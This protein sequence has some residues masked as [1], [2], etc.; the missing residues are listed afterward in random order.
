M[1]LFKIFAIV[2]LACLVGFT[3]FAVTPGG[4]KSSSSQAE[5]QH[6]SPFAFTYVFN[7]HYIWIPVTPMSFVATTT[8]ADS[9]V[10][11]LSP[12]G[13]AGVISENTSSDILSLA[14]DANAEDFSVMIPCPTDCDWAQP[15]YVRVLYNETST[16]VGSVLFA[17]SYGEITADTTAIAVAATTTGVTDGAADATSATANIMQWAEWSTL[18]ANT[19]SCVGGVDLFLMKFDVTL[20][21]VNNANVF[22]VQMKCARKWLGG[23]NL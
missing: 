9:T 10:A 8:A 3:A 14:L 19:L 23:D 6:S 4:S 16:N 2:L 13:G 21:T 1:K 22:G 5:F 7:W 17:L 18:A 15:V 12:G 20:V 11:I